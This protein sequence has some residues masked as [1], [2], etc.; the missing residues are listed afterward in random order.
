MQRCLI[1]EKTMAAEARNGGSSLNNNNGKDHSRR[2]LL[3]GVDLFCLFLGKSHSLMLTA[4]VLLTHSLLCAAQNESRPC[5][6]PSVFVR[7]QF[8]MLLARWL[9]SSNQ[10]VSTQC[11]TVY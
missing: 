1:Y 5:L 7:M 8:L 6:N 4:C 2:K 9:L 11:H 10:S 3:V